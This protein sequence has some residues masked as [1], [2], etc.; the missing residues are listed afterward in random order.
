MH[1]VGLKF[2]ENI[3]NFGTIGLY[4]DVRSVSE[5]WELAGH[6]GTVTEF[7]IFTTTHL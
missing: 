4:A 6:H 1:T 2:I 3:H 5:S 7:T